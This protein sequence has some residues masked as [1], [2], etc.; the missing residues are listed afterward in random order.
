MHFLWI[1]LAKDLPGVVAAPGNG[2]PLAWRGDTIVASTAMGTL[3]ATGRPVATIS[4]CLLS[5][6]SIL[7]IPVSTSLTLSRTRAP[8]SRRTRL[9]TLS[10]GTDRSFSFP[11]RGSAAALS[12]SW[13]CPAKGRIQRSLLRSVTSILSGCSVNTGSEGIALR[14]APAAPP[15][16]ERSSAR[17]ESSQAGCTTRSRKYCSEN[18]HAIHCQPL[19]NSAASLSLSG[20]GGSI[21]SNTSRHPGIV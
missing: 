6:G 7:G 17:R 15:D 9:Q 16:C 21:P 12:P 13:S 5:F 8:A 18:E 11:L 20:W 4:I 3:L 14:K 10:M 1:A 19:S 2:L